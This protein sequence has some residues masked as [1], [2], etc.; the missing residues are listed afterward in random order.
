VRPQNEIEMVGHQA[1]TDEAHRQ[2]LA[3]R[4]EQVDERLIILFLLKDVSATVATIERV[5]APVR[6]G[7][8][9]SSRQGR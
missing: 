3:G 1:P 4:H 8:S 2:P 9:R 5:V 7:R 6:M